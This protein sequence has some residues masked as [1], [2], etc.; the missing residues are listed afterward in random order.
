MR[1]SWTVSSDL[2]NVAEIN[3]RA[4]AG[5]DDQLGILLGIGE[6]ALRLQEERA[7]RA[8]ELPRA[9]VAGAGL[10]RRG[11]IVDRHSAN[12][13]GRRIGLDPHGRF[14]A[15]RVHPRDARQDADALRDLGAGIV[16]QLPPVTVLLTIAMY[17]IAWSLGL[18]LEN[19]G[20]E[21]RST[22]RLPAAW[23]I[24]A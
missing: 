20:G 10:D 1:S 13:Q 16:V 22:G 11:Q 24:A 23:V 18:V 8:V 9:F 5:G 2:G 4:V 19:V 17:M 15:V 21:G 3:R 12:G 7:M 6:L 14:R